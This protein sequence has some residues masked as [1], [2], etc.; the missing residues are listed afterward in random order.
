V[1]HYHSV[2]TSD[3][4]LGNPVSEDRVF[5]RFL[6][7]TETR[8]MG[9][10][11]DFIDG[12]SL[13]RRWYWPQ[14]HNDVI[15]K[16]LNIAAGGTEVILTP[17]NHDDFLVFLLNV[18]LDRITLRKDYV[19]TAADGKKY[20]IIHGH[21]FDVGVPVWIMKLGS[22][23]Y[24]ATVMANFLVH[25]VRDWLHLGRWSLSAYLKRHVKQAVTYMKEFEEKA[26]EYAR[27]K[28]CDGVICGHIHS[29]AIK[30]INGL[31]YMNCGDWLEHCSALVE[32]DDGRF[33]IVV[34]R[35]H[36]L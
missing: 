17:G 16:I 6:G 22:W 26:V 18:H 4:H 9:L 11:G 8:M 10:V 21:Q 5:L 33:E 12:W 25:R 15:Q 32:G 23:A 27:A 2:W 24:D 31:T 7:E 13:R 20:L 19:Y 1:T 28:G 30:E 14:S 3:H 36:G 34:A 35:N 29:P